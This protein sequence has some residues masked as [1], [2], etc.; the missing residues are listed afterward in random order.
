MSGEPGR[1]QAG[2][3]PGRYD[4]SGPQESGRVLPDLLGVP[5][6]TCHAEVGRS[7]WVVAGSKTLAVTVHRD[8]FDRAHGLTTPAREQ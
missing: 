5:C 4:L 8:R 2:Q 1:V 3:T 7:C 6:P